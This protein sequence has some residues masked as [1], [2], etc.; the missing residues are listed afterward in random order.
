M[1]PILAYNLQARSSSKRRLIEHGLFE[2]FFG[3]T[4]SIL[5]N[6]NASALNSLL[7]NVIIFYYN[8]EDKCILH[9]K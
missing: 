4:T 9:P 1:W 7:N 6:Q 3:Q 5:A 8:V 2:S